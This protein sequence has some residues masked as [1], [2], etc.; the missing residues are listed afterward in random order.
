M[1][2]KEYIGKMSYSPSPPLPTVPN[3]F[4]VFFYFPQEKIL[5]VL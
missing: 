3:E 4:L 1:F 2:G 5:Q